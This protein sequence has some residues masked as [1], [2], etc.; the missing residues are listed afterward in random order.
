MASNRG[1]PGVGEITTI[2]KLAGRLA[3]ID[4]K[5]VGFNYH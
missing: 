3:L 1:Q 4:K 5:K 2:A